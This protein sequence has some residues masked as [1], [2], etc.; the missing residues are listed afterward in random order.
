MKKDEYYS[1][2]SGNTFCVLKILSIKGNYVKVRYIDHKDKIRENKGTI[3]SWAM[4]WKLL[5]TKDLLK[6]RLEGVTLP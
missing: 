4:H 1:Y 6:L 3:P 5:S 2:R